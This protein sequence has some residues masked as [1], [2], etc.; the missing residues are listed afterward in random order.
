MKLYRLRLVL[1]AA[2][3]FGCGGVNDSG[4][5]DGAPDAG[6]DGPGDPDAG[7]ADAAAADASAPTYAVSGTVAGFAGAGMVLRL[8]GSTDVEITADGA[9]SFPSNLADG[10][11]YEVTMAAEPTCPHRVC[12]VADATGT[13][14][15]ADASGVTVTCVVPIFRLASHNWGSP[16]GVRITDDVL[17]L[18]SGATA[19]PRIVTGASTGLGGSDVDSLAS[20][21]TRDLIYVPAL[22]VTPSPSILVFENA[23]TIAG[24]VAPAR[25]IAIEGETDLIG[26]EV[27]EEA[28][29]LYVSGSSGQLYIFDSA[30]TL[31][32]TVTPTAAIAL[33][34]PGAISLDREADRLYVSAGT[35]ALYELDGAR[36]LTSASTVSRTMTW[37]S[38]AEVA[39]GI[40]ID[41]C[42]DRLYLGMRNA[43]SNVNVFVLDSASTLTGALD[44]QVASQAT[45]TV[46]DDQVMSIALDSL[47]HLYFWKDSATAVRIID[48]PELLSGIV[49]VIPDKSINAV[50]ASGY[51]LELIPYAP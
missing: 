47:G 39:Y 3:V 38:P 50:V 45:L 22:V 20:D 8:N 13:I 41:G 31:T 43:S 30:S 16:A 32:G 14:S 34:S 51:G 44:L 28:D 49:V 12:A 19:V 35:S 25:Q 23:S 7:G 21:R 15:G 18:A 11:T 33:D 36:Q 9:F 29:R 2:V 4:D 6:D 40:A 5:D 48:A 27:D 26:V 17:A 46:P 37:T 24:D 10:A 42:R 1:C